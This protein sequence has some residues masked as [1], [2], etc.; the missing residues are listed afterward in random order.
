[1]P[2]T[3]VS[4]LISALKFLIVENNL[5]EAEQIERRLLSQGYGVTGIVASGEA[6]LA[7]IEKEKPDIVIMDIGLDGDWDG[8]Q[9]ARRIYQSWKVPIIYLT[10]RSAESDYR[11][12]KHNIIAEYLEKP[13]SLVNLLNSIDH[14]TEKWSQESPVLGKNLYVKRPQR[15]FDAI[16]FDEIIY[17]KADGSTTNI[18][19]TRQTIRSLKPMSFFQEILDAIPQFERCH[20]SYI[21]NLDH[22]TNL[23]E[24]KSGKK[25]KLEFKVMVDTLPVFIPLGGTHKDRILRILL[26]A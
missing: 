10:V 4:S 3:K 18:H 6:A 13:F 1:M 19:S 7:S 15:G 17:L 5:P 26:Q 20:Y 12:A 9:T 8:V 25:S 2:E 21:I 16:P 11:N 22:V 14:I 23:T 24:I